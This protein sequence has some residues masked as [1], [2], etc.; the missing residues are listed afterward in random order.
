MPLGTRYKA[1]LRRF[2]TPLAGKK[3]ERRAVLV[4][5]PQRRRHVGGPLPPNRS[6]AATFADPDTL[7]QWRRR[8]MLAY[9]VVCLDTLGQWRLPIGRQ[10]S[11]PFSTGPSGLDNRSCLPPRSGKAF[12]LLLLLPL[13]VLRVYPNNPLASAGCNTGLLRQAA[14]TMLWHCLLRLPC[15]SAFRSASGRREVIRI[16]S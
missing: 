15:I 4:G 12:L 1:G 9:E 2:N 6:F 13:C 8:R 10:A 7:S 5:R 11:R 16:D 3:P 14:S